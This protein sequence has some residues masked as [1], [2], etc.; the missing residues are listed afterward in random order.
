SNQLSHQ[1]LGVPGD[2]RRI[3]FA[4]T[5]AQDE[6]GRSVFPFGCSQH[7]FFDRL[8]A[9]ARKHHVVILWRNHLNTG[10]SLG[11]AHAEVI[12]VPAAQYPD[13]EAILQA[14]DILVCDWSSIAFD[15]LLLGRPAVFLDV[16][17]PFRKGFS[18][19][20]EYR[21]GEI[22]TGLD[23][24]I[25]RLEECLRAPEAYW[26]RHSAAHEKVR[27]EIYGEHADGASAARCVGRLQSAIGN[28]QA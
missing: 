3:L 21:Y 26:E 7:V 28:G 24:L 5:W 22:T 10:G 17:A 27:N 19:G 18:L 12:P 13:T 8:A 25:D 15:F 9:V 23:D 2:L 11:Q 14:A 1:S 4:P 6:P 20:P 16:P